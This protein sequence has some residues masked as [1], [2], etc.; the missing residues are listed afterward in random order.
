[1]K[2][3]YKIGDWIDSM[4]HWS[5]GDRFLFHIIDIKRVKNGHRYIMDWWFLNKKG[6]V[7]EMG[8][9]TYTQPKHFIDDCVKF[10]TITKEEVF[11]RFL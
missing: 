4:N 6:M 9:P 7:I 2:L 1:M 5:D 3:K 10:K 8:K 11:I